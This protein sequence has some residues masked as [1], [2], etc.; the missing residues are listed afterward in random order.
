MN[1]KYSLLFNE[2]ESNRQSL[3]EELDRLDQALLSF[4]INNSSWSI[5]QVCHH[6]IMSEE[7]S[8]QYLNKKLQYDTPIPKAN[9]GSVLR[10]T[11]INLAL[12]LPFRFSAPSRV[13]EFPE[14]L[15]WVDIK[16]RWVAVRQDMQKTLDKIPDSFCDKLV[17]KHP[18]I[19]RM[20]LYQM[21]SFFKAHINRHEK[22]IK[23]VIEQVHDKDWSDH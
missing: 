6:L 19:G 10:S 23:R 5:L 21:L 2:L 16:N 18:S 15:E 1:T 7:L 9:I 4:K 17:Y 12:H 11:S 20:T 13:S 14:S 8:L 3:F 22:Q